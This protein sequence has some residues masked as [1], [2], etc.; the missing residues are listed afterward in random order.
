MIAVIGQR[1]SLRDIVARSMSLG[2]AMLLGGCAS[3][4]A[5]LIDTPVSSASSMDLHEVRLR[6]LNQDVLSLLPTDADCEAH[7]AMALD[8][9]IARMDL[10]GEPVYSCP[11]ELRAV[12][13]QPLRCH[14]SVLV[15]A[16]SGERW[17]LDNGTVLP[18]SHSAV[19]TVEEFHQG[20]NGVY[21]TG[22]KPDLFASLGFPTGDWRPGR[23]IQPASHQ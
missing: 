7:V 13:V 4:S 8:F 19:G 23:S 9:L 20:T 21:W 12:G 2:L 16:R 5:P 6:R 10:V 18:R 15:A 17:V 1:Q 11:G 22:T 3:F 14:V